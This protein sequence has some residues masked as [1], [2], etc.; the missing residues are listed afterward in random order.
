MVAPRFRHPTRDQIAKMVSGGRRNNGGDLV[1]RNEH[2]LIRAFEE[3]FR[4]AGE[5]LPR[6]VV[7]AQDSADTA[8]VRADEAHTLATTANDAAIEAQRSADS[9]AL[10]ITSLSTA[11][12]IALNE[13]TAKVNAIIALT[14]VS[15]NSTNLGTFPE[16]IISDTVDIKTALTELEARIKLEHPVNE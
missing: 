8:Q 13:L 15:M 12:T 10:E 14:G 11:L 3:V 9:N 1:S 4:V 6:S 5:E 16:D 7:V 2:E